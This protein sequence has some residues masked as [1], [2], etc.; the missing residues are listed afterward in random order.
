LDTVF[1]ASEIVSQLVAKATNGKFVIQIFAAGEIVPAFQVLDAVSN[2]TVECGHTASFFYWGK[3]PAL[4]FDYTIPFGLNARQHN[5]WYFYGGG[6]AQVQDVLAAYG[7]SSYACGNF[8]GQMG[9]WFRT[10][11]KSPD[12]LKGLKM[13][14]GGFA[15]AMFSKVGGVPQNIPA[16][17]IYPALERGTID[18]CEWVGPYDDQKLGFYKVAK[19]YYYPGW[20]EG[21]G[22]I[23]MY[24]NKKALESLP[25]EYRAILEAACNAAHVLTQAKYDHLN[26]I[27]LKE[28]IGQGATLRAFPRSVLDALYKATNEVLDEQAAKNTHFKKILDTWRPYQRDISNWFVIGEQVFDSY[29]SQ[30]L[31]TQAAR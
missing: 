29:V 16:G 15:G 2:S 23:S 30:T 10:E 7:V 9:G 21:S 11:I 26:P 13:R 3:E 8:G 12:D 4:A 17:D 20:Q 31:R 1:G 5:A 6:R 18:A 24:V 14:I 19:N 22:Q 25:A 28:L 27:A